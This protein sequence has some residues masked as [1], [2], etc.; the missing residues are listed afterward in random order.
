[1]MDSE[2][3]GIWAGLYTSEAPIYSACGRVKNTA[4]D[5]FHEPGF[6]LAMPGFCFFCR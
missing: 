6:A 4:K 1:M 5:D 2:S 3:G